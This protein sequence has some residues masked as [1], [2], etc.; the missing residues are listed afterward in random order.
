MI[1]TVTGAG[2]QNMADTVTDRATT[3][4]K[5]K[6]KRRQYYARI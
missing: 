3:P 2:Q 4:D 5:I 1:K 6:L